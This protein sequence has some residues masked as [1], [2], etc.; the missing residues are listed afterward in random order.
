[1]SH[2]LITFLGKGY[3]DGDLYPTE[4]YHFEGDDTDYYETNFFGL[5]VLEHLAKKGRKADKLVVLGTNDSMWDGF[6]QLPARLDSQYEDDY[7]ALADI[8]ENNAQYEDQ[9]DVRPY[10]G[11]TTTVLQEYLKNKVDC[12]LRVIPYGER[13]NEQISILTEMADFIK[14]GDTV[15]LDI[16]YGLRH[17]PMLAVQSAMLLRLVK[18]VTVDGI[19]YGAMEMKHLHDDVAPAVNLTGLLQMA[20]WVDALSAF[21]KDG[22]YSVFADLLETDGLAPNKTTPLKEA[23][24]F[25]R[26]F[27]VSKAARKLFA[28]RD[29]MPEELPGISSLFG[30]TLKART[31]WATKG[32]LY[33]RQRQLAY[34]F[35]NNQDYLRAAILALEAFITHRMVNEGKTPADIADY[36]Q[37]LPFST[38]VDGITDTNQRQAFELLKKLRNTMAS[39]QVPRGELT[40]LMA[41]KNRLGYQLK[42]L[43]DS[44]LRQKFNNKGYNKEDDD[45]AFDDGLKSAKSVVTREEYAETAVNKAKRLPR[46]EGILRQLLELMEQKFLGSGP[47]FFNKY[48]NKDDDAAFDDGLKSAKSVVTREEYAE[49]RFQSELERAAERGDSQAQFRLG[50]VFYRQKNKS[51]IHLKKALELWHHSAEQKNVDA[52]FNL[53]VAYFTEKDLSGIPDN[54]KIPERS[55]FEKA[56]Q[57][58]HEA[59]KLGHQEA[60]YRLANAY[61]QGLGTE[62]NKKE[63]L[64]WWQKASALGHITAQYNLGIAYLK[65][66][67]AAENDEKARQWFLKVAEHADKKNPL[68]ISAQY[69]LGIW[70]QIRQ[71]YPEARIWLRRAAGHG[72]ID[73]R[74]SEE[75]GKNWFKI[76][77]DEKDIEEELITIVRQSAQQVLEDI[78]KLEEQEKAKKEVED[79]MAM[80]AHKFR[81]PL[82]SIQYNAEHDNQKKVTLQA[83]QTMGGLLNIFSTVATEPKTLRDKLQTDN[84]GTG[85]L[86]GVLEKVLLP[87]IEQV[88][89]PDNAKKI[90]QHY[91][92]YAKKTKQVPITITRKQW[93]EDYELEEQL[94]TEWENSFSALLGDPSLDKLSDWL[95][96]HFFRLE[97]SGFNDDS[98]HFEHYGATESLLII[99][100]NEILL[101]AI[102][103]YSSE[104]NEPV[105]LCWQHDQDCCRLI[106]ENP[107][108]VTEQRIDK[109]TY[110]GHKFLNTIA[111]KLQGHFVQEHRPNNSYQVEIRIPT[112]LFV[113]EVL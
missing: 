76:V 86:A 84:A 54:K 35:L 9:Q 5:A 64:E 89:T 68:V 109:G 74:L 79:I 41:D 70:Y 60:Q 53:G 99:V 1:M 55:N 28:F 50:E 33:Q 71:E 52:L 75:Y 56:V 21:N 47:W 107:S 58:W 22:D 102:K 95:E 25:E 92:R 12:E 6:Y 73:G 100:L 72:E 97:I 16:S 82:Q 91:L 27:N 11:T 69:Q 10:L 34:S 40:E 67:G 104:T 20:D 65:G 111:N 63:A 108:D 30:D 14:T 19:Y 96:E 78:F 59:A 106:C 43:M 83:V 44:L 42:D 38:D 15:S 2:I 88:L 93:V 103:Y 101:N 36:H 112:H 3:K 23:A 13:Q 62:L 85:T 4:R 110:K 8:I 113:K 45:A 29:E 39:G 80:F 46:N 94:Q 18:K 81:G 49:T 61:Y 105:K 66:L 98:I 90:R 7:F 51:K 32:N 87:V 24:F 26:T 17:L 37:R 57:Y 77:L 48:N 31:Q